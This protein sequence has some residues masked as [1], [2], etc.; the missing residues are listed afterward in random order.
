MDD[1]IGNIKSNQLSKIKNNVILIAGLMISFGQW[2]DTRDLAI[3]LY[4]DVLSLFT[5]KLE[6][7][8]ISQINIGNSVDYIFDLLGQPQIIRSSQLAEHTSFHY[9]RFSDYFLTII[10]KEQRVQAFGVYSRSESFLPTIPFL[11]QKT[12]LV[13]S[14]Y[15]GQIDSYLF[16][17]KNVTY[18]IENHNLGLEHMYTNV[19]VGFIGYGMTA[20]EQKTKNQLN[21]LNQLMLIEETPQNDINAL[22]DSLRTS[23]RVN[24]YAI[25]EIEPTIVA[26]SIFTNFE[27]STYAN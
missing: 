3:N 25:S 15:H 4:S 2:N 16:D 14:Q 5:N 13:F 23:Q 27:Y 8:K 18:Y 6:Y 10:S 20:S 12:D 24:Y 26:E 22:R 9:Y 17:D 7:N 21:K 11:E 19:L 1:P